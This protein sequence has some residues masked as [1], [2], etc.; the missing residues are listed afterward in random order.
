L[1]HLLSVVDDDRNMVPP[2][3]RIKANIRSLPQTMPRSRIEQRCRGK[4]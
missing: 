2:P 3:L 4:W 1:D